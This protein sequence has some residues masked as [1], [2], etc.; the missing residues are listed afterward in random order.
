MPS[1]LRSTRALVVARTPPRKVPEENVHAGTSAE[2]GE[3]EF[4]YEQEED[5]E[6]TDFKKLVYVSS[7][8]LFFLNF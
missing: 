8:H 7:A 5:V 4:V 6:M 2:L 1:P 3:F